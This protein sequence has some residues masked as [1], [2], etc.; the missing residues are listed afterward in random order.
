MTNRLA[1]GAVVGSLIAL[2]GCVTPPPAPAPQALHVAQ[3]PPAVVQTAA[4]ELIRDGFEVMQSDA[5]GGVLTAQRATDNK[6]DETVLT[7]DFR[8]GSMLD[9][10]LRAVLTVSLSARADSAGSAVTIA[11][12]VHSSYP[13]LTG[14]LA[15]A[16]NDKDCVSNGVTERRIVNSLT[17]AAR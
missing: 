10:N 4:Q 13:R 9:A 1:V 15:V 8:K 11:A 12:H 14:I 2:C 7:C 5:A 3:A 17:I 6:G 16:E